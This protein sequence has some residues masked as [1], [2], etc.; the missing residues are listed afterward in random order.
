MWAVSTGE[1]RNY[2]GG[3]RSRRTLLLVLAV[4]K[5]T[6]VERLLVRMATVLV[7]VVSRIRMEMSFICR[8]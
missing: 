5:H 8:R 3:E 7:L 1:D 2:D 6:M 4:T